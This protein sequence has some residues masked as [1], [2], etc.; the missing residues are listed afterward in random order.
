MAIIPPK[1]ASWETCALEDELHPPHAGRGWC[2]TLIA[3]A[4]GPRGRYVVAVR[5]NV[6]DTLPARTAAIV[7]LTATL[8]QA[9]WE[10]VEGVGL[11]RFRRRVVDSPPAG[12]PP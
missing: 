11:P 8:T 9:A 2:H 3:R 4:Q 10:P 6:P 1:D 12:G 7:A 5:P